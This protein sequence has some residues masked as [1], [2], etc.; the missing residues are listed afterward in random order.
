MFLGTTEDERAEPV[1][2]LNNLMDRLSDSDPVT[3]AMRIARNNI[4]QGLS[5][6]GASVNGYDSEETARVVE[7]M[8]PPIPNDALALNPRM[9]DGRYMFD[10]ACEPIYDRRRA[11]VG[12]EEFDAG[13][14]G[15]DV[16][17]QVG[18][19][20]RPL[21]TRDAQREEAKRNEALSNLNVADLLQR[22]APAS[23]QHCAR[24]PAS[25]H[26]SLD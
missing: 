14:Y 21:E 2:R 15:R 1:N 4:R 8:N 22:P 19:P 12:G 7:Q 20:A 3:N 16:F 24:Q 5:P 17:A 9:S 23:A 18:L 6:R 13:D 10:T 26:K 11:P 25:N